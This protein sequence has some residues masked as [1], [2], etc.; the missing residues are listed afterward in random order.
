MLTWIK[1]LFFSAFVA[2][3]LLIASIIAVY[4]YLAPDLPSIAEVRELRL[5][6]P[7]RVYS[8]DGLLIQEFGEMR[9][10]PLRYEQIPERLIHAFLAAE[11]DRYFEHPGVDYQGLAAA[12]VELV[13]TGEP[14][15]GGST[16][17]MQVARNLF[18]TPE[19]SY[20]RKLREIILAFRL[21]QELNKQEILEI[22]LN[23][24]FLGHRSY[25]IGAAAHVYYGKAVDD[26]ELHQIAMIAGLPKAPSLYNPVTNPE[27]ALQRRDYVLGRMHLLGYLSDEEYQHADNTPDDARLHRAQIEVDSPYIGEMVRDWMVTRFGEEETYTGGY[28]VYTT[29]Y[30]ELQIAAEAAVRRNLRDYD[31]RRGYRGSEGR[32]ELAADTPP[33]LPPGYQ[34]VGDLLPA[35]VTEVAERSFT[36]QLRSGE[37]V[38]VGWEGM[39]WARP[40]IHRNAQGRPPNRASD[41]VQPGEIIRLLPVTDAE[42]S[43][44]H[45]ELS[46][47]PEAQGALI[48]LDPEDGAIR[49]LVGGYDFYRSKFNRAIQARRQ[50]GSAFK[51]VIFSAALDLG[52]HPASLINDAPVVFEDPSLER[53]WRPENYSGEFFGPTRMRVALAASRNLVAI[54]LLRSTGVHNTLLQSA[55]FGLDPAELPANLSLSLGT[56]VST[57]LQ[58]TRTYSVLANGG[59]RIDPHFV[60]TIQNEA[61]ETLY[62]ADPLRVCPSCLNELSAQPH[63]PYTRA[64][65][66]V[67]SAQN[68]YFMSS[69]LR[70]VIRSGTATRARSLGRNDLAGKTGTTNDH[71]DT[72][73]IGYHPTLVVGSWV[74]LDD[75]ERL[76]GGE[77]GGRTALPAWI[78]F[79]E[80]ALQGVPEAP[81]TMPSGV[82]QVRI[83]PRTGQRAYPGQPDAIFEVF[84]AG[85]VPR[86]QVS[87][88]D[89]PLLIT[90]GGS[91]DEAIPPHQPPSVLEIF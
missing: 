38:E 84:P 57:P 63:P 62:Q 82:V 43:I 87:A 89:L 35:L 23:K 85:Q 6:V 50:S 11:D 68:A 73:F 42:E 72:W 79:M 24:I 20:E 86:E 46:Q 88:S 13:T 36:A 7:L 4:F 30:S 33:Q 76:G 25:G 16:I 65:P 55:R 60:L 1:R 5:Q 32:V 37:A 51:P 81:L 28:H 22:Y 31:R 59:Y 64:A 9:R 45:W 48:A 15:R 70:D 18:L 12:V 19:K 40:F 21:E 78:E 49:A 3:L 47:I 58:M 90:P 34:R 27:R 54:R 71:R 80:H 83:D 77:S 74:G 10:I 44:T 66:Q 39:R 61:G 26:L 8:Q 14:R 75:N 41:I 2:L 52:Y 56:G 29:I 69:M 67:I 17:T 53:D 91:G